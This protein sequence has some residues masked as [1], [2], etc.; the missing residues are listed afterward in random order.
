MVLLV[1][2]LVLVLLLQVELKGRLVVKLSQ[3]ARARLVAVVGSR[4]N[5]LL[6]LHVEVVQVLACCEPV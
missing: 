6:G 3:C 5:R 2:L 4:N 1:L